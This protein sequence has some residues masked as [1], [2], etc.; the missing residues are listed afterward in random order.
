MKR[1]L[2]SWLHPLLALLCIF[3]SAIVLG[4]A[5]T[6]PEPINIYSGE[7]TGPTN[8]PVAGASVLLEIRQHSLQAITNAEGKFLFSTGFSGSARITVRADGFAPFEQ[9]V[10]PSQPIHATLSVATDV[11][12]VVVTASRTLLPLEDSPN[13]VRVVSQNAL[14]RSAAIAL[15]DQI[16]Q[17][18]GL[19]FFR[20]SSNLVANPTSEGVSLRGLGSTAASRTLIMANGIPISDPFGGWIYWEQI[21]SLAIQDVEVVS[22]GVS[23]LYGTSAIGG[24]VNIIEKYPKQFGYVVDAGYGQQNTPHGSVLAT[25]AGGP[26]SGM[27]AADWLRTDGY[28]LIAPDVRGPI[29]TAANVHYQNGEL[30]GRRTFSDRAAVFLRGNVLNE[31]RGN[32]TPLQTNANRLWRYVAGLDWTTES[33][34]L[35][36]LRAFGSQEHYRQSFSSVPPPRNTETLTRRQNTATQQLGAAIQWT[37]PVLPELTLV[38]GADVNDI[39]TT[40]YEVPISHGHPNGLTDTSARQRDVGGYTEALLQSHQWTLIGSL[41]GD[42]FLNLDAVQNLQVGTGPINTVP[43]PDRSE[44]ILSA[45]LGVVRQLDRHFTL[46]ASGYRAFRSPTLNEL[47]RQ[48]QVG[49]EITLANAS[50]QSE[51]ATGWEIGTDFSLPQWNS[52]IRT[53]YFWT[54]VNRPVSSLTISTTPTTIIQQRQNLGQIQSKGIDLDYQVSPLRWLLVT[55]GYQY[56]DAT[57]TKF[58]QDPSLVGNW[59]PQVPHNTATMQ[60]SASKPRIGVARLLGI[61]SGHQFDD[62]QNAFLLHGYFQLDGYAS[63]AFGS[64]VEVYGAISNIFDRS[65]EVG[66]TPLLT[67][68]SPRLASFGLRIHS[69]DAAAR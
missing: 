51:R 47:Y 8:Q 2:S 62:D 13:T 53:S 39:R 32:G 10:L 45:K 42:D 5:V 9:T 41:R 33:A 58:A 14:Q 44:T 37:K 67:L 52:L 1:V 20:R 34:G 60:V 38:A 17:V 50:L 29:D 30:F 65:I 59:I 22:G 43:I 49:Q 57:V 24:A 7:V 31:A 23:N 25:A 68:G 55:G 63:H 6:S 40:D 28:M 35:F 21:P 36:S 46:K 11:Q 16:R 26:W 61:I 3:T 66:K 18:T 4:Q 19:S 56:A 15:G 48:F 27:A 54:E 12:R 64:R 69:P